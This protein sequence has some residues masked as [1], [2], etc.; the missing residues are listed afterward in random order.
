M[1]KKFGLSTVIAMALIL[2]FGTITTFI[3]RPLNTTPTPP[4]EASIEW[5]GEVWTLQLDVNGET[6]KSIFRDFAQI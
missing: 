4:F 2:T 5:D 3:A 6:R 1:R